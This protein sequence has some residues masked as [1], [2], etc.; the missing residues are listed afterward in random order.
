MDVERGSEQ[1]Q[2]EDHRSKRW[3]LRV[4]N[5]K[6]VGFECSWIRTVLEIA[7]HLC[8]VPVANRVSLCS[9]RLSV[10]LSL[11]PRA[12][13]FPFLKSLSPSLPRALFLSPLLHSLSFTPHR[14]S[15]E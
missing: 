6:P 1:E 5:P 14:L 8:R 9:R 11:T 4:F 13:E 15:F 7:M 3:A 10:N 2:E 12:V